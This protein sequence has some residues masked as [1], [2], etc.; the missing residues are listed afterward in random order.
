MQKLI[1]HFAIAVI[2]VISAILRVAA[3]TLNSSIKIT[4]DLKIPLQNSFI[5]IVTTIIQIANIFLTKNANESNNQAV[6]NPKTV[7]HQSVENLTSVEF[8]NGSIANPI[9]LQPKSL[10]S[11]NHSTI[12]RFTTS[13]TSS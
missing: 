6:F 4:K 11:F 9:T 10:A 12:S 3:P 1:Y 5:D 8:S 7:N 2:L 13:G